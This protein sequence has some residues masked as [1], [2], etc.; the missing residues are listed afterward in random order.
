MSTR[1]RTLLQLARHGR[2]SETTLDEVEL[3]TTGGV[4]RK[5]HRQERA[6][7]GD[8]LSPRGATQLPV[9]TF[10]SFLSVSTSPWIYVLYSGRP[11]YSSCGQASTA[12]TG[13]ARNWKVHAPNA[14]G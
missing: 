2:V 12:S 10:W 13:Y 9:T 1:G 8:A 4:R 14:C 5:N 6:A 7:R 3:S 11:G